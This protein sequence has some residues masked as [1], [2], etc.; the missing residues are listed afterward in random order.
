DDLGVRYLL[1]IFPLLFVWC[2][3]IVVEL[4]RKPAGIA[5]ALLLVIWQARAALWA[6]PNYIPYVNEI[7]GGAKSGIYYLDDSNV[8]WGQG[9]KQTA[10]YINTHHRQN[11]EL[12]PFS[13][14]DCPQCYGMD[15]RRL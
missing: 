7:A 14:F 5:L 12:L 11:V 2:S 6:F 4:N 10:A 3:R 1:P 8:D 9:M 15:R 13:P